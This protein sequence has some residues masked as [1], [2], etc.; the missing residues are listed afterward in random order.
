MNSTTLHASLTT[1]SWQHRERLLLAPYA[2]FSDRSAGR[3]FPEEVHPYRS[4]FQRDRDRVLHSAAFR[5][6]S[7]KMQVFTG[8]MGDYH[9][10]RLT[11][12]NEV[13]SLA[14]TI[15]RSLQ[16]NEDLIEAMAL[17]HDIGHPPF[18]HC[19]EDALDEC[20]HSVGGFSHNRFALELVTKVEQRYTEYSGL[21]LTREVLAG[22]EF[23]SDKENGRAPM[24]EMQVV[25]AADSMAYDAHDV[26]DAIK[27]G[28]LS[29]EQ[30]SGLG[31]VQRAK[32]IAPIEEA[33]PEWRR[34][35]L[36]HAL[37][38]V[39]MRDF[40]SNSLETLQDVRNLDTMGVQDLGI[41]LAMSSAFESDKEELE[42]FLFD[43]VYRHPKLTEIRQRAATRI[44]QL[45][46]LLKSYPDRLP[47]RFQA[48]V[49]T[50]G[51]ERTIATYIAGMTD[52]FCD[53]QYLH[54]VEM[55]RSRGADWS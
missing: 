24:L 20:T 43:H 16:L 2:M 46:R 6:L 9:R 25:D 50:W 33:A 8:D 11:H 52:R 21:N 32:Q 49:P 22:Q 17:L 27:L 29:W 23:R 12:T 47:V 39:Q 26:D 3:E 10:T 42:E 5:R 15:G 48:W 38:D 19:G 36:V 4:P 1:M 34:Q 7:G 45:F 55:G 40:L 41:R 51:L 31:L 44:H 54:L 14:R 30:L 53:D 18:G 28:L 13:S 37:L 35:M